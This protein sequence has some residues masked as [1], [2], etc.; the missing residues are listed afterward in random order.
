M[1]SKEI[2]E[3]V[4]ALRKMRGMTQ[5]ELAEKAGIG[6]AT[7]RNIEAGKYWTSEVMDKI[8]EA[9]DGAVY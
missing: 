9:L 6:I 8:N 7:I 2:S 1:G 4:K 5:M 3:R